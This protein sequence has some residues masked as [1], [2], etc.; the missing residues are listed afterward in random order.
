MER[1]A[2]LNLEQ[3]KF[4]LNIDNSGNKMQ[5]LSPACRLSAKVG[6]M[7]KVDSLYGCGLS[8]TDHSR[9]W[10]ILVFSDLMYHNVITV[11]T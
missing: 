5:A 4:P 7:R 1:L 8:E 10:N 9:H 3:H 2:T 6:Q 11:I